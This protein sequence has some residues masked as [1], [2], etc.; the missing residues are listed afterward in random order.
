MTYNGQVKE[1]AS[2]PVNAFA[3]S[4]LVVAAGGVVTEHFF[5]HANFTVPSVG[6]IDATTTETCPSKAGEFPI[7]KYVDQARA[8]GKTIVSV[9]CWADADVNFN[10][11]NGFNAFIVVLS[12]KPDASPSPAASPSP[13][14]S[15]E[16]SAS[17]ETSPSPNPSP[18]PVTQPDTGTPTLL[19]IGA[20]VMSAGAILIKI[21]F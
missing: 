5:E 13:L 7:K 19:T 14:V 4:G 18:S 17:P 10:N 11:N 16:P 3:D 20:L 15:P 2:V 8:A 6:W 9:Q 12:Y 21:L 1:V